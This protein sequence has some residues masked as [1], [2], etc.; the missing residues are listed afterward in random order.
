MRWYSKIFWTT[1]SIITVIMVYFT[2][3]NLWQTLELA[4]D[5]EIHTSNADAIVNMFITYLITK[6]MLK[7]CLVL[8]YKKEVEY[9]F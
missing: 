8:I 1:L 5:G 4:V 2:G 3:C 9:E 6:N 7:E